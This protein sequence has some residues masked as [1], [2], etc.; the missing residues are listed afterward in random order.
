MG[1]HQPVAIRETSVFRAW[2]QALR[3]DDARTQI[4]HRVAR[5][6]NGLPG[7]VAPV[8]RGVSELRIDLGPGYRI[9]FRRTRHG[10]LLLNGGDKGTQKRD[11]R[12]A[13]R[14]DAEDI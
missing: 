9:Y 1:Y 12:I 13:L 10:F 2:L 7:D 4:I 8:G 5:L 11:I 6:A 14:M 3:D